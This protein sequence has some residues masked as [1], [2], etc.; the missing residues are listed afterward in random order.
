MIVASGLSLNEAHIILGWIFSI[1]LSDF[2]AQGLRSIPTP[3]MMAL[4]EFVSADADTNVP[5]LPVLCYFI[6]CS[7]W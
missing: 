1:L 4:T 2:K 3:P 6:S 5:A 7:L